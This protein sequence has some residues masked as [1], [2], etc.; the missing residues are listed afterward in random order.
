MG[1][2]VWVKITAPSESEILIDKK[3]EL[4]VFNT[5]GWVIA[6]ELAMLGAAEVHPVRLTAARDVIHK[7]RLILVTT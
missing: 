5:T 6:S 2:E 4:V 1:A 7:K 3:V